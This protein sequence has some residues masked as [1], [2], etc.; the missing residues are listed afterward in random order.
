MATMRNIQQLRG[1]I[2]DTPRAHQ[3]IS[4]GRDAA[5]PGQFMQSN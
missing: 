5:P 4:A 2:G 1:L 3:K